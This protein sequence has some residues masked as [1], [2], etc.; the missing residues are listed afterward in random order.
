MTGAL[1]WVGA[2]ARAILIIGC[3][4]AVALPWLAAVLKPVFPLFVVLVYMLAVARID[5]RGVLR[6]LAGPRAVWLIGGT[7]LA[8]VA[9]AVAGWGIMRALGLGPDYELA[10]TLGLLAPPIASAAAFCFLLGFN[11]ALAL[12]VTVAASLLFPFIAPPVAALLVGAELPVSPLTLALRTA[13][14]IAAGT[15][16][17]IALRRWMSPARVE[18]RRA[19]FDGASAVA[20]LLFVI[21]L[22]DGFADMVLARP[23]LAAG[24]LA[25]GCLLVLGPQI[26]ALRTGPDA[27]ALAIA[28]GVRSV[29]IVVAAMPGDAA[30]LLF[31][32]LYQFPMY[33]LPLIVGRL[34]ET[35]R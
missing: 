4:A 31:A 19:A 13:G 34:R 5:L 26:A 2:R 1:E 3:V 35:R 29:G 11:A 15:A 9:G 33:A 30:F 17:G 16:L 21:P 7:A 14:I 10:V 24:F 32:A 18:V 27:G 28:G 8:M 12:E 23:A 25:L 22:F 6:R 20:M